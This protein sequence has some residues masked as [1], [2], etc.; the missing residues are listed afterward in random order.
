MDI[1]DPEIED[2]PN[3]YNE[4]LTMA[5]AKEIVLN[6]KINVALRAF[7]RQM[8]DT[9]AACGLKKSNFAVAHGMHHY[10][11]YSST[12]DIALLSRIAL[13]THPLL[14]EIVNTKNFETA[15]K[16]EQGHIY[17]WENTNLMLWE[18]SGRNGKSA[19]LGIKT[20]ITPT[21]GPCLCVNFKD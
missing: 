18:T 10:D 2:M 17:K 11:N 3:D 20:G 1:P 5:R 16:I 19:Y 6:E 13:R 7:Y 14:V 4:E 8:N 12:L 9:A 21:A 15:S